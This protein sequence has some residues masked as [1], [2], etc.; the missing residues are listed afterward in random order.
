MASPQAAT[1]RAFTS[2]SPPVREQPAAPLC[3]PP[4]NLAQTTDASAGFVARMETFQTPPSRSRSVKP[5]RTPSTWRTMAETPS[6]SSS[7][8]PVSAMTSLVRQNTAHLPSQWNS[9][10]PYRR[11]SSATAARLL[12]SNIRRL[13]SAAF[14]PC[15]KRSAAMRYVFA[16]AFG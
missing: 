15:S 8:A 7:E 10:L 3:P 9:M 16:E 5:S 6:R 14:A 1:T 11:F 12:V 13:I 2:S 4:P